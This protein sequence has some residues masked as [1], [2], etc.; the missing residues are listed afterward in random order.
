MSDM[1]LMQTAEARVVQLIA[2]R[3]SHHVVRSRP[4]LVQMADQSLE[5]REVLIYLI[6]F[7]CPPLGI[8]LCLVT[9]CCC[10]FPH[11]AKSPV[12]SQAGTLTAAGTLK[13]A[14]SGCRSASRTTSGS[15]SSS[16]CWG[17]CLA[18]CSAS[19]SLP[20]MERAQAR[21]TALSMS[22]KCDV[23]IHM[24]A[25]STNG[26]CICL[27][28]YHQ[29]CTVHDSCFGRLTCFLCFSTLQLRLVYSVSNHAAWLPN[30]VLLCGLLRSVSN[31]RKQCA[32]NQWAAAQ[33]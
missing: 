11:L 1:N 25:H 27:S 13:C 30:F 15:A 3:S 20:G 33:V 16:R 2:E 7:L 26:H 23:P 14:T 21:S 6:T 18:C 32:P 28:V 10:Y 19:T 24:A 17:G 31:P 12:K 29:R 5:L 22:R 8:Y 4:L 9:S